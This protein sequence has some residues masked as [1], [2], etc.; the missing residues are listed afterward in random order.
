LA[1]CVGDGLT[2]F[3]LSIIP[4]TNAL[5]SA[6]RFAMQKEILRMW[7]KTA[8]KHRTLSGFLTRIRHGGQVFAGFKGWNG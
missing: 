5:S 7:K 2:R 8:Q 6:G 1:F 3:Y 4:S